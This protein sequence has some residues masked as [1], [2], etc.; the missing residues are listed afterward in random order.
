VSF[1]ALAEWNFKED[2]IFWALLGLTSWLLVTL[3]LLANRDFNDYCM[4]EE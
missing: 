4:V 3:W 1:E 2:F